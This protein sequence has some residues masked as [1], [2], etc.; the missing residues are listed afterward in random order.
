[1]K[2]PKT[3]TRKALE[4]TNETLRDTQIELGRTEARAQAEKRKKE[5]A[6]EKAQRLKREV[7][8]AAL[9]LEDGKLPQG[10]LVFVA[11]ARTNSGGRLGIAYPN[12]IVA[13][14]GVE[15]ATLPVSTASWDQTAG[16]IGRISAEF[17]ASDLKFRNG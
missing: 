9:G 16:D 7:I 4:A 5:Q 1:M 17:L 3:K 11:P 2:I 15:M 8:A 13:I 10:Q 14:E 12:L 6:V